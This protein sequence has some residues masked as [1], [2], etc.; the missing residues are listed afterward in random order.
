MRFK[1]KAYKV[2]PDK[3]TSHIG[4]ILKIENID[5][6]NVIDVK[7]LN[8]IVRIIVI[9]H[10]VLR[11][12]IIK[13]QQEFKD[14]NLLP[15][16][17]DIEEFVDFTLEGAQEY[18]HFKTN[19]LSVLLMKNPFRI[20]IYN[21]NND[22]VSMDGFS[23]GI[24]WGV[25]YINCYKRLQPDECIFGLGENSG[26]MDKRGH[27]FVNYN[28]PRFNEPF[29]SSIPFYIGLTPNKIAYGIFVNNSRRTYFNIGKEYKNRL[30]FGVDDDELNYYFIYGPEIKKVLK[31]YTDL[32][33]RGE[34]P[35]TWTLGYHQSKFSYKS[36]SDVRKIAERLRIR[37]IPCD[38][39]FLDLH[40]MNRYK[41]FTWNRKKFPNPQRLVQNLKKSGFHITTIIDPWLK[42]NIYY[43]PYLEALRNDF[44]CKKDNGRVYQAFNVFT[45]E[46]IV[47]K[48][49]SGSFMIAI[50]L[51]ILCAEEDSNLHG[52][53]PTGSLIL[54]VYQFRH[55][56]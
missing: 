42:K 13:K 21:L 34:L 33:G 6:G 31:S 28:Y 41:N 55:P 45:E 52:F 14:Y 53:Y 39:I 24:C 40:Y 9:K 10:D 17:N 3:F 36:D 12:R 44:L 4:N 26:P 43:E 35:P 20:I 50:T 2:T 8:A 51:F 15:E 37:S 22:L 23:Y 49:T 19:Q 32:T 30:L 25:D 29:Y 47:P 7:C 27:E 1:K 56:R 54:R 5:N 18:Y 11:V 48:V 38:S 46:G 16:I